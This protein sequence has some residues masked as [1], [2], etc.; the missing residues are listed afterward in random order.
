MIVSN[1]IA[2]RLA[3][4]EGWWE[5]LKESIWLL[6]AVLGKKKRRKNKEYPTSEGTAEVDG[7]PIVSARMYEL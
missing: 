1:V 7:P 5:R 4:K 2:K 6:E 3:G